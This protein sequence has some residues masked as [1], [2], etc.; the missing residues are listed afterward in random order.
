MSGLVKAFHIHIKGKRWS[1]YLYNK[2]DFLRKV[3]EADQHVQA[4][5]DFDKASVFFRKDMV[6]FSTILHEVYHIFHDE[7]CLSSA[8]I[9]E[10]NLEEILAEMVAKNNLDI[11]ITALVMG[12]GLFKLLTSNNYLDTIPKQRDKLVKELHRVRESIERSKALIDN[13]INIFIPKKKG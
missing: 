4:I 8:S 5:T 9:D 11:L 2:T 1:V 3:E 13:C 7:L 6:D 10:D 12:E